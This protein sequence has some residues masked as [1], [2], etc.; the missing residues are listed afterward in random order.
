MCSLTNKADMLYY[1]RWIGP[2]IYSYCREHLADYGLNAMLCKDDVMSMLAEEKM[3]TRVI[4]CW[5]M[6]LNRIESEEHAAARMAFLG[7]RH[8][9]CI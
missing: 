6:L 2:L 5:S 3:S 9:V 8:T 4:E 1:V 7:L